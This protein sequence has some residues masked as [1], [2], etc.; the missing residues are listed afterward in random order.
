[1][2]VKEILQKI[3]RGQ[4]IQ[5]TAAL[6]A[7]GAYRN[8]S[9]ASRLSAAAF[10]PQLD[11]Q[12]GLCSDGFCQSGGFAALRRNLSLCIQGLPDDDSD[13]SVLGCHLGDCGGIDGP[14]YMVQYGKRVSDRAGWVAQGQTDPFFTRVNRQNAHRSHNSV[15][16]TSGTGEL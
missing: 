4:I 14:G 3:S 12:A 1:M 8:A 9:R 6:A 13:G 10:I 15:R 7:R 2:G 5:V 16:K 11:R